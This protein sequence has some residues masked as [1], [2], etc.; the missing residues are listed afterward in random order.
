LTCGAQ[1][2][3]TSAILTSRSDVNAYTV[4]C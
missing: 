3:V 2:S 4:L 1:A